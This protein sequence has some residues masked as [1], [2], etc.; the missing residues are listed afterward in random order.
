VAIA[1]TKEERKQLSSQ[2]KDEMDFQQSIKQGK[3]QQMQVRDQMETQRCNELFQ[4]QLDQDRAR[5]LAKREQLRRIAEENRMLA[6][7]R[8]RQQVQDHVN[9][10]MQ[11]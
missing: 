10:A 2:Y 11:G 4:K 3:D 5:E 6:S 8:Q 9:S 7:N 1:G